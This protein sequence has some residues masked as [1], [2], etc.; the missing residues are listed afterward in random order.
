MLQRTAQAT[1]GRVLRCEAEDDDVAIGIADGKR[2]GAEQ[3]RHIGR[4]GGRPGPRAQ[5]GEPL[6]IAHGKTGEAETLGRPL[7]EQGAP[8]RTFAEPSAGG[9]TRRHIQRAGVEGGECCRVGGEQLQMMQ[10]G[11]GLHGSGHRTSPKFILCCGIPTGQ[12][13]A[14]GLFSK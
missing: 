7:G 10:I 12:S 5:S 14:L 6:G 9:L 8:T 13:A 4:V 2:I 11:S 3:M 1:A